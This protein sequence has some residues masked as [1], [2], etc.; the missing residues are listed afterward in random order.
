[1]YAESQFTSYHKRVDGLDIHYKS[2]G[3]GPPLILLHGVGG[4]C[5]DWLKDFS[6]FTRHFHVIALDLPGF[7]FSDEPDCHATPSWYGA[8]LKDFMDALGISDAYIIGHSLGG[9]VA[10]AL[11]LDFPHKVKKLVLIDSAGLG[12]IS[13]TG[14]A[15][16]SYFKLKGKVSGA[17]R[18]SGPSGDTREWVLADRL[19]AVKVPL[20]MVWGGRDPYFPVSQ[21]K[22]AHTLI[23]GS[24]LRI[25]DCTCHAPQREFAEEFHQAV[26]EFLI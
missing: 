18:P 5:S 2:L 13:W 17:T 12:H 16:R 14:R 23:P 3:E 19:Q 10:L 6:F 22:Q 15:L 20:M 4:D 21:A 11:A 26:D 9:A 1:M 24:R 25:F 8:F 7:G